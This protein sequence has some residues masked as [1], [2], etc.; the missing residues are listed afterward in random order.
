MKGSN[1]KSGAKKRRD[2]VG[3]GTKGPKKNKKKKKVTKMKKMRQ[4]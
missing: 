4:Q 3:G 1:Y 2:G